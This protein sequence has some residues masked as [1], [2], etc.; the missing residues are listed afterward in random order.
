MGL[1]YPP[2]AHGAARASRARRLARATPPPSANEAA[3]PARPGCGPPAG[4]SLTIRG[5]RRR[6]VPSSSRSRAGGPC[7]RSAFDRR[8]FHRP[9]PE[10]SG[11]HDAGGRLPARLILGAIE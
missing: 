11:A 7:S 3:T 5:C 4:A 2:K 1:A 10:P 6:G 9:R 8:V